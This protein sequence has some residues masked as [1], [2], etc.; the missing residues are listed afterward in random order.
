MRISEV[1][2]WLTDDDVIEP[3]AVY[4]ASR[5]Y[6]PPCAIVVATGGNLETLRRRQVFE[7][8]DAAKAR[9]ASVDHVGAGGICLGVERRGPDEEIIIA[10]AVH[11]TCR[12]NRGS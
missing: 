4:V 7:V 5:R 10:V 6:R 2:P 12:G 11:I 9:S 8:D 1:A 3:I